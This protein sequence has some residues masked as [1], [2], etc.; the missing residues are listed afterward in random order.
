MTDTL[1]DALPREIDRVRVV[2]DTYKELRRLPNVIVEPQIMMMEA[3]I[4]AGI[5]AAAAGDVVE[6]IRAHEELKTFEG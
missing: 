6:M 3:A 2:Q 5:R 4:Q 1:A